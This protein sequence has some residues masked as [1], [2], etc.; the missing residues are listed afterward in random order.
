ML[1]V[2]KEKL[3]ESETTSSKTLKMS[4]HTSR[5]AILILLNCSVQTTK[6]RDD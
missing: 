1:E 2:N 3:D 4:K 6:T 5:K